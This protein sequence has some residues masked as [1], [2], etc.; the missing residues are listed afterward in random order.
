MRNSEI[1]TI[2][3]YIMY[4]RKWQ[5]RNGSPQKSCHPAGTTRA[6]PYSLGLRIVRICTKTDQRDQRLQELKQ[7][8]LEREYNEKAIDF[9]LEK[10]R[11]VPRIKAIKKTQNRAAK[12]RPVFA[13]DYDPRLPGLQAIQAKH[14]RAM[15]AQ[16]QYLEEVFPEPPLTAFRR[17]NNIRSL[18]IRAKVPEITKKY[19]KRH[20]R[21]M[22]KCGKSCSACPY[23][24]EGKS[25]KIRPGTTWK[26]TRSLSC[27]NN[28]IIYL[29]QCNKEF[30]KESRYIGETGRPLK[31]RL[32][33]HRGY[34]TNNVTNLATGAHF[35]Q[36]GH[37]LS[38][39]KVTILEQVK[40]RSTE[41]RKEREKYFINLFNTFY[42]GMNRRC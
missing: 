11:K 2:S 41:Y 21:G 7:Y 39:L 42:T 15:I 28:N 35:T 31:Y 4:H 6:I 13:L 25:I 10:A 16:D 9:S 40:Q 8:L 23:I 36:A 33:D 38:N 19:K 12:K 3:R 34:V 18:L 5:D 26:L 14:W 1:Y 29:I 24:L 37:S 22:R 27:E 17:Q 30:C 32:A 20:I